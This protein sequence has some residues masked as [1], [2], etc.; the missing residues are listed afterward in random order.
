MVYHLETAV[1]EL[2]NSLKTSQG[3]VHVKVEGLPELIATLRS[4]STTAGQEPS[5]TLESV[6]LDLLSLSREDQQEFLT[7][8]KKQLAPPRKPRKRSS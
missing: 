3:A 8:L 4:L 1:R 7:R 6:F 5:P 2:T